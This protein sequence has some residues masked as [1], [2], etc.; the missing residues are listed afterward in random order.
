M[1]RHYFEVE[2]HHLGK[3]EQVIFVGFGPNARRRL[4]GFLNLILPQGTVFTIS[5][6]M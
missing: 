4:A 1:R 2:I 6:P 3:M 5:D